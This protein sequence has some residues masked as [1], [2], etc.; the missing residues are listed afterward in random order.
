MSTI[1]N[2][3]VLI[4]GAASGM[5]RLMAERFSEEGARVLMVDIDRAGLAA[6]SH[7]TP[8]GETFV[9][10][11]SRRD[12][13]L[14]LRDKVGPVDILINNA[15][16]IATG[17]YTRISKRDDERMLAVNCA[18]VHWMTK[19]FLPVLVE[20]NEGHLVQMA[21]VASM[22]GVPHQALYSA[23]KWFVA[24]LSESVRQE[25]RAAGHGHVHVTIVCPSI[26][27][28]GFFRSPKAPRFVPILKPELVTARVVQA[29]RKNR[30]YV[31]EPL[32]VKLTPFL[33]GVLPSFVVDFVSRTLGVGRVVTPEPIGT[34]VPAEEA[35]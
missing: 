11:V 34:R 17:A 1:L 6:T 29:V 15:G 23:T 28:T 22:I 26:V 33:R 19:T 7:M 2:R 13:V 12:E 4:T 35:D 27:D 5:G 16:V 31:R 32:M 10:D 8:G 25:L 20:S 14:A 18:A 24:G 30:R 9:C 21:S 3:R